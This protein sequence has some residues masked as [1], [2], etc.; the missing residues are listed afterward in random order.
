[1]EYR[2]RNYMNG[3]GSRERDN[4]M[5]RRLSAA[6]YRL[7][8]AERLA[9]RQEKCKPLFDDMHAW[10]KTERATLSKSSEVIEPIDY[11]LKR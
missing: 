9:A 3:A 4:W 7:S 6:L 10:L 2:V 5:L 11:M 8:A 1:M